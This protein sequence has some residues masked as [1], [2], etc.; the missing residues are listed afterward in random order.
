MKSYSAPRQDL[1]FQCIT[2]ETASIEGAGGNKAPT[3]YIDWYI[4]KY[5]PT[6]VYYIL[7]KISKLVNRLSIIIC[8]LTC[9]YTHS[10][11]YHPESRS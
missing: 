4:Q 1:P 8:H 2:P 7:H 3:L 9:V 5:S 11:P 10:C 6:P